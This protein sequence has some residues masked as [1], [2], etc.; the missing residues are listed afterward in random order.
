MSS[1]RMATLVVNFAVLLLF[2]T[3]ALEA[4]E[5]SVSPNHRYLLK[6]GQPF[7]YLCD[8][9]WDVF[10]RLD[11]EEADEY[12][13]NRADKGF[14]VIMAILI[15]WQPTQDET[16]AY[17]E[18]PLIDKNPARPNEKYFQ[19]VD[20]IVNKANSLGIMWRWFPPG[21]TE[22]TKTWVQDRIRST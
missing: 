17:G 3:P 7:F 2:V 16:N 6:D 20:Y 11:R 10:L 18:P 1:H 5:L 8:T 14:N 22:C 9:A 13:K 19:H 4:A 21:A 15:G 12:L